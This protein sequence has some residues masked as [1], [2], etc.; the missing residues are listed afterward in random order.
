[1]TQ[2]SNPAPP[3]AVVHKLEPGAYQALVK[4]CPKIIV[5][6]NTTAHEAG[7]M[8][9]VQLVLEKLREGFVYTRA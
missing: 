5:G 1:M 3:I 4:L 9:G 8:L 7:M 6:N 2:P